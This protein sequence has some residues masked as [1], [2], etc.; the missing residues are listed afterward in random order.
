MRGKVCLVTGATSGIGLATARSLAERGAT[1]VLVSRSATRCEA[2]ASAIREQSGNPAVETLAADLSAQAEIRRAAREFQERFPRL[3][4]LVNNA[5]AAFLKRQ[6]SV[7]GIEMTWA[8]N[9]LGYFLLTNLLLDAVKRSTPARVVS[10]SSD[11]HRSGGR[12]IDFD[13]LHARKRYRPF[14]AYSMSKLANLLFTRELARRLEGTGVTAN[15]MHP[16]LVATNFAATAPAPVRWI[17][18]LFGMSPEEGARTVIYLATAPEVEGVTGKYF[19]KEK[20]VT[21]SAA[22]LNDAAARRL[23]EVSATMTGLAVPA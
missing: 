21:P 11:A 23:W 10:V 18:S 14:R 22:A 2:T 7:D 4:I 3:D 8:L 13:D 12:G 15:A 17:F 5:G 1:V 16:G 9:H 6:E 19:V 20:E